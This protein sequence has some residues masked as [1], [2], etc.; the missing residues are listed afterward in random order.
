MNQN[1]NSPSLYPCGRTLLSFPEPLKLVILGATGSI[2]SQTFEIIK[3]NPGKLQVVAVSC[4]GRWRQLARELDSLASIYPDYSAPMVA[5]T[6][7]Q[8][9]KEA[10][11]AGVFGN[12][13]LGEGPEA[14]VEAVQAPE[15]V[16]VVVNGVVGAA[17]LAPTLA[18]ARRGVRIALANKESL[19]VGGDLVIAEVFKHGSEILPVDSEHSAMA[20]CLSGRVE[21]EV[22]K[23]ILTASGGPFRQTSAS[24][25][26]NVTLEQV[27]KHPTWTM[28]PKITVDSATLMNKGLEVI[29]AHFLFGVDYDRIDVVVHPGSYIHSLVE[30]VDGALLAQLGTPDMR[31][32]IQ[33]AI[34]GE[35]HWPLP[36]SRLDLLDIGQLLFEKPDLQ[37]FPCLKLAQE[38]GSAGGSATIFLNGAN[39]VAVAALLAKKIKYADIPRIIEEVLSAHPSESVE[40]LTH[41]LTFDTQARSAAEALVARIASTAS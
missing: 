11:L 29:E 31:L 8:A 32:P 5:I 20:Q 12:R 3:M 41:A 37:R 25:L 30:F 34:N 18:A 1:Q 17:G 14:M 36:G 26:E 21:S 38:A 22:H 16:H 13:L 7:I 40:S 28:G 10:S 24:D 35:K 4:H 9:R 2:G 27:L 23:L 39:E 6:D 19:V 15:D 33:Y